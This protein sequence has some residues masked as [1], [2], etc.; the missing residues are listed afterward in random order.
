M[1]NPILAVAEALQQAQVQQV[2]QAQAQQ[3]LAAV[4]A[5]AM[6]NQILSDLS[7]QVAAQLTQNNENSTTAV[8]TISG[9]LSFDG[10]Q[11][12]QMKGNDSSENLQNIGGF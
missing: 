7:N 8:E 3:E 5:Q 4:Q 2:Q 6:Q 10:V 12:Q 11:G 9:N 1:Q